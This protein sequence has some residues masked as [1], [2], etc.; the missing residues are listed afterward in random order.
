MIEGIGGSIGLASALSPLM[1]PSMGVTDTTPDFGIASINVVNG[2][3]GANNNI[4]FAPEGVANPVGEGARS[5]AALSQNNIPS[6]DPLTNPEKSGFGIMSSDGVSGDMIRELQDAGNANINGPSD[7][8][9]ST[10]A[11]RA[12]EASLKLDQDIE[13]THQKMLKQIMISLVA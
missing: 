12:F 1:K 5:M 10:Q 3:T 13:I 7:T 4:G 6:N 11:F 8:T 9:R 2:F